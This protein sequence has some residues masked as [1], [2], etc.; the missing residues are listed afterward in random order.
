MSLW[1]RF[2]TSK[3]VIEGI[4]GLLA[5]VAALWFDS[6]FT[7]EILML[8]TVITGALVGGQSAIDAV[9]GSPSDGTA[10]VTYE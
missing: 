7:S 1:K 9:H 5:G 3:K 10:S 6:D 8:I 4:A 2:L